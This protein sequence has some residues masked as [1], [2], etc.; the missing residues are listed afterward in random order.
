[1]GKERKI[2]RERGGEREREREKEKAAKI[3]YKR[4]LNNRTLDIENLAI[5]KTYKTKLIILLLL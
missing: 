4:L 1:M 3:T 2:E 5:G